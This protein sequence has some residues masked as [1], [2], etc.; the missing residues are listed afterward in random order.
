MTSW[1]FPFLHALKTPRFAQCLCLHHISPHVKLLLIDQQSLRVL[2]LALLL[3][4]LS[5]TIL[6]AA[7]VMSMFRPRD[8]IYKLG[9]LKI[10]RTLM[11]GMK[12][13]EIV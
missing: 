7:H 12:K 4:I 2:A 10:C 5:V 1:L 13:W 3:H 6:F 9:N 8:L 11:L